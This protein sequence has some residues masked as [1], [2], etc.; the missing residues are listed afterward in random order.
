MESKDSSVREI[1][2]LQHAAGLDGKNAERHFQ[3]GDRFPQFRM[4]TNAPLQ[5]LQ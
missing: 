5:R 3:T 2:A 4:L 1:T